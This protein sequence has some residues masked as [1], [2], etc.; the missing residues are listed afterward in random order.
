MIPKNI[1]SSIGIKK[2]VVFTGNDHKIEIWAKEKYGNDQ[3]SHSDFIK[4][5]EKILG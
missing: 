2:E 4:L 1:L 3:M 5:T